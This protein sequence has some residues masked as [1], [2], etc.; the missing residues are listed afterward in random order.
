MGS[1]QADAGDL[2]ELSFPQQAPAPDGA[3]PDTQAH[4]VAAEGGQVEIRS[5][6]CRAVA[7]PEV[8]LKIIG[9]ALPVA[10]GGTTPGGTGSVVVSP[11]EPEQPAIVTTN[12]SGASRNLRVRHRM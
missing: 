1:P 7:V 2:A 8:G 4:F 11:G 9:G 12:R 5:V 10:G 3:E 6:K